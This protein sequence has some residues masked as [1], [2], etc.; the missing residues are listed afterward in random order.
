MTVPIKGKKR[1]EIMK[2]RHTFILLLSLSLINALAAQDYHK[3]LKR[4]EERA[5]EKYFDLSK[6][7]YRYEGD[8]DIAS[9]ETIDG[10][11]LVSDGNMELSGHISGSVVV[12]FGTLKLQKGAR[13]DGDVA[14]VNGRIIQERYAVVKG[15][16]IETRA[17]NLLPGDAWARRYSRFPR[18]GYTSDDETTTEDDDESP[19]SWRPRFHGAYSTLPLKTI[20]QTL[21]VSY[22]RVQGLFTGLSV[23]PSLG[24]ENDYVDI[25]GF[26]GYGFSDYKW[27]YAFGVDRWIFDRRDYRFE[28]G[29][30]L[31]NRIDSPDENWMIS[32]LENSLSA[33]FLHRDYMDFYRRQGFELHVRQNYT[34]FLQGRLAYR[35]EFHNSVRNHTDWA[36]FGGDNRRF[37]VNP[38]VDEGR[39]RSLYG[40]VYF[41]TRNNHERPQYG[42]Y[43][44]LSM[45][46]STQQ[47]LGSDFSFNRY[48]L[49]V[50]HYTPLSRSEQLNVRFAAGS[51]TGRFPVQKQYR[52]GG[53]STLRGYNNKSIRGNRMLLANVE[54]R[55]TPARDFLITPFNRVAY[56]I[57]FDAGHAWFANG[58]KPS[59]G[60]DT[61]RLRDFKTDIGI[62]LT[63]IKGKYRFSIA[64]R[65]DDGR[66]PLTFIFRLVK[67]F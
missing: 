25:H 43:A 42:W 54:Y 40:E 9:G 41:D 14:V 1:S 56:I 21:M 29:G 30:A 37:S 2:I 62:A 44:R 24:S 53:L 61:V 36:L 57:Y 49:D 17:R 47:G 5:A 28:I 6:K 4:L 52:L 51:G 18:E 48:M 31:Y 8:V 7:V 20:H 13:V 63:D 3:E 26:A 39:L 50:R 19:W 58:E 32:S 34:I 11:V 45:E 23:P 15:N 10:N 22:N 59:D 27:R 66:R 38:A 12:L 60:F 55:F 46:T 67:P 16:Q 65:L 35:S 33:F 64:K